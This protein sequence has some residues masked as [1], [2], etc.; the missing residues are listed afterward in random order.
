MPFDVERSKKVKDIFRQARQNI[1]SDETITRTIAHLNQLDR[2]SNRKPLW[3][4]LQEKI[5][6]QQMKASDRSHEDEEEEE[7]DEEEEDEE[8]E[9]EEEDS[10]DASI[11]SQSTIND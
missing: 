11:P 8:E 4:H 3:Q 7:E 10:D 9:D 5:E 6:K 1:H 2:E